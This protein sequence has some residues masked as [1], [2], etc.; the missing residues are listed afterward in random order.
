MAADLEVV[1]LC[2][3]EDTVFVGVAEL[4]YSS[5]GVRTCRLE[6]LRHSHEPPSLC[7]SRMQTTHV[8]SRVVERCGR[9]DDRLLRKVY[10]LGDV[11]SQP[12][13]TFHA[14]LDFLTPSYQHQLTIGTRTLP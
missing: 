2:G 10:D 1:N 12:S 13:G 7:R 11:H 6:H 3:I 14:C 5:E 8:I 9:V 4:K